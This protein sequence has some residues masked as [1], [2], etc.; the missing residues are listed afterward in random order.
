MMGGLLPLAGS[1]LYRQL[2]PHWAGTLLGLLEVCLI[3]IPFVFYKYGHR[4]RLRSSLIRDMQRD[5]A[6]LAGKRAEQSRKEAAS[7]KEE[8]EV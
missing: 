3:P 6:R 4:I 5:K 2:G 8:C 1:A 7:G